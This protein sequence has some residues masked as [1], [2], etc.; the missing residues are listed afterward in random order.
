LQTEEFCDIISAITGKT[1]FATIFGILSLF[2]QG[3]TYMKKNIFSIMLLMLMV[4]SLM[5]FTTGCNS[6]DASAEFEARIAELEE[7]LELLL[8]GATE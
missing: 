1:G 6:E 7:A 4:G 5:I 3:G 2:N 8:S